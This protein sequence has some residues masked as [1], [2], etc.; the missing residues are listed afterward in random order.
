[1]TEES[2]CRLWEVRSWR[3]VRQIGG[4]GIC[5][6]PDGRLIVVQDASTMLRLVQTE[7]GGTLARFE[8]P[9]SC[10][11]GFAVFSP[12][13]SRLVV[14]TNDGPAVH[15]WDLRSI[16]THLAG[17]GLDWDAPTS[18]DDDPANRSPD[19]LPPLQ[20]DLGPAVGLSQPHFIEPAE[21][22][23]E[24]F[25]ERL[26]KDPNDAEAYHH[27][28]HALSTLRRLTEV[29]DDL[30]RAIEQQPGNAHYLA[31]RGTVYRKLLQYA[32]AIADLEAALALD[33]DRESIREWL[34]ICCNNRAW[35][36]ANDRKPRRDLDRALELGR[37]AGG[38]SPHN[39]L[40]RNTLGVVLYR[41]AQYDEAIATLNRNVLASYG[42]PDS[43]DLFFL[44]MAHHRLGH[45]AQART[46]FDRAVQWLSNRKVLTQ[47]QAGALASVRAE[48]EAV[49]AGPAGE[50]PEDVFAPT[51]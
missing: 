17:M 40:R 38:L 36:L 24:R 32:L 6:S 22:L 8:T 26:K 23:L 20:V 29:I 41:A 44:A 15:V 5:F 7:T 48:A 28:G 2:P 9:D 51:P 1:M 3:E 16:R 19:P 14:T 4:H 46:G 43:P 31:V 47:R 50:L 13:G 37:R 35:D 21:V 27:R 12:D 25:T 49:L 18:S 45:R 11:V 42:E 33:T 34:A 10:K 39:V 30:T